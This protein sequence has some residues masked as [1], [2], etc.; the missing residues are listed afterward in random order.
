[1]KSI[2]VGELKARFSEVL[3]EVKAGKTVVISYGRKHEKVAA[4]VPYPF[5][6]QPE[7]R[8]LGVLAGRA[9]A[10]FAKD[11]SIS[12]EELLQA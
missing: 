5:A 6:T 11:F 12:D 3:S 1:M 8:A 4:L 9:K 7:A 10:R 2:Q